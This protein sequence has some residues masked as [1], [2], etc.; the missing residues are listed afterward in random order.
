[1]TFC[2]VYLKI[3]LFLEYRTIV[4]DYE[5]IL[6][7]VS[8]S[9][10]GGGGSWGHPLPPP[11]LTIFFELLPPPTRMDAPHGHPPLKN[12]APHLKNKPPNKT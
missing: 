11:H 2:F 10:G 8:H 3:S 12:E 6:F 1:M 5:M 4:F 7:R 9:G